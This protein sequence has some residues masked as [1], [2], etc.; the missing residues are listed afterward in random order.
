MSLSLSLSLSLCAIL[1]SN[2]PFIRNIKMTTR[3]YWA[4]KENDNLVY[5]C[6]ILRLAVYR[7]YEAN[8]VKSSYSHQMLMKILHNLRAHLYIVWNFV[9]P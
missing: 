2:S 5:I 7:L 9:F 3:S 1:N 6:S 4:V 8:K